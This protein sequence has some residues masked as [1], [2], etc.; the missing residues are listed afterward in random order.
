MKNRFLITILILLISVPVFG[1]LDRSI[2]PVGK[3]AP[4]IKIKDYESFELKN[5]LKVFVI[6]SEKTP[7]VTFRLVLDR[8]PIF[9]GDMAGYTTG[10]GQLL[11]R[12]TKTRTKA[13]LDEEIDFIGASLGTSSSAVTASA[14]SKYTEKIIELMADVVL[15]A[16]FKQEELDKIK[17]QAISGLATE[18]D[19]PSAISRKMSNMIMYGKEHPY[20]EFATPATVENIT[21]EKCKEYYKTFYA[22]NIAYLAIVGDIKTEDAKDL[23]EKYFGKWTKREVPTYKYKTSKA[24]LVR[25]VSLI[26]RSSAVQSVVSVGYPVKLKMNDKDY[27]AARVANQILGGSAT[28]RL[29]MNLR[30][31]KAYTYGAYSSLSSDELSGSFRASCQVKNIVSDSSVAEILYEMEKM[32]NEKITEEELQS[33]K[34]YMSGTFAMS[35]EKPQTI[36]T[37]ALNIAINKLPK[38]YYNNYVNNLNSLTIDDIQRV[39][40]KYF[41]PAKAHVVVV[42]NGDEVGES[43]KRLSPSGKV[44][45]FDLDGKKFDPSAKALPKD[46]TAEDILKKSIEA[47]GGKENILKLKEVKMVVE[48][49]VQGMKMTITTLK[50]APNK[51]RMDLN[52]G[53][54]VQKTIFDGEKCVMEAMGQK[55]NIEGPE[56]EQM[57]IQNDIHAQVNYDKLGYTY[58]LKGIEKVEGRDA[59]KVKVIMKDGKSILQYYDVET[60]FLVKIVTTGK[61]PQGEMT[62]AVI[63]SDYKQ[64]EGMYFPHKMSTQMGPMAVE[65]K[66]ISL[67]VNKGIDDSKF[68]IQ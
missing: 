44:T 23:V 24:P 52:V 49:E 1:Q 48:G 20:G 62:T 29:F 40:K 67:E 68:V 43:L 31:D 46:L 4:E 13:Q 63:M 57:K 47:N 7:R 33:T 58:E 22:P 2:R 65:M 56:L 36:A 60:S 25:K 38:D 28:A 8:D 59:Y 54:M 11:R 37:F 41:K 51:F 17:K 15:N 27:I 30:E 39:S 10:T 66:C 61:T 64:V 12:G 3:A 32:R 53:P 34:N 14:L 6:E 18:K 16:D 26:D 9:E 42:G 50:K 5:G 19:D 35:L 21:L 55:Q 45:W